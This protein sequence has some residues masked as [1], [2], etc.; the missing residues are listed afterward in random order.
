MKQI[1]AI[2]TT[3][4]ILSILSSV[5]VKAQDNN[6]SLLSLHLGA[7]FPMGDY[8]STDQYNQNAGYALTGFS[9]SLKFTKMLGYKFGITVA[10]HSEINPL[11]ES[12]LEFQIQQQYP[13][14]NAFVSTGSWS[15]GSFLV[16]GEYQ[17]GLST[18]SK[19]VFDM[20]F[21]IGYMSTSFPAMD[22]TLTSP[23]GTGYVHYSS[24]QAGAFAVLIGAGIYI[25]VSEK[26][27][28]PITLD[29]MSGTPHF[30]SFTVQT[31]GG[32]YV[33]NAF[34][35]PVSNINL[36]TGIVIQLN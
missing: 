3:I 16:G 5:S 4:C 29:Y 31:S 21:L 32:P 18:T 28:I 23:A 33:V 24:R 26:I 22:F 13:G 34:D 12:Q 1:I 6:K 19:S 10:T 20:S 35:Q 25:S 2:F 27:S 17:E 36:M 30:D 9:G 11:N 7:A 15:T 14:N 8:A